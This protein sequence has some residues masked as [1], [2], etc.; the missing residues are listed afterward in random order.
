MVQTVFL[1]KIPKPASFGAIVNPIAALHQTH[2][3]VLRSLKRISLLSK[4]YSSPSDACNMYKQTM[5][6]LKEFQDDLLIHFHL[7]INILFPKILELESQF[8]IDV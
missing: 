3:M 2:D 4:N 1:G 7:E 6:L 5:D 8:N